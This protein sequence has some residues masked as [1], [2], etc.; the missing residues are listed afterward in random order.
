VAGQKRANGESAVSSVQLLGT[1]PE[2]I[3]DGVRGI[4]PVIQELVLSARRDIHILAYL[5]TPQA[6]R[7]IDL[8]DEAVNRSVEI[9]ILVNQFDSQDAAIQSRLRSL[10]NRPRVKLGT[11]GREHGRQLHAKVIVADRKSAVIGSANFSWGGMVTNYEV[12]VLIEGQEA[13]KMAKLI[14]ELLANAAKK[15]LEQGDEPT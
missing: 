12:G 6:T 7:L 5:F 3:R 11:L 14:D 9:N 10:K 15:G 8:L 13:W 4:E 1:G 2:F